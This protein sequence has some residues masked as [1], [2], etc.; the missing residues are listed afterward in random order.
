M[1]KEVTFRS[2]FTKIL[3]IA[4]LFIVLPMMF[5]PMAQ[6][7]TS[8]YLA[9]VACFFLLTIISIKL[10]L[11]ERE[12]V[13]Y[14]TIAFIIQL[15]L[16]LVHYLYFVDSS[17]FRSDGITTSGFWHEYLSV[18]DAIERLQNARNSYGIFYVMDKY[19]FRVSHPEIWHIISF[20][21][22]FLQHKWLNYSPFNLFSSLIASCNIMLFYKIR[23]DE[24]KDVHKALLFWTAY[25]PTFL[26]CGNLW[27]DPFGVML[28][29]VGL[30]LVTLSNSSLSKALSLL[31]LC[32]FSF[33][34]RTVY[35]VLSGVASVW[36]YL[37][38]SKKSFVKFLYIILG[39]VLI[40]F[41]VK[42]TEN[43]NTEGYNSNYVNSM[44]FLALPMKIVLGLI[45]PFP[46]TNF[47]VGV[48]SNPA[49]AWEVKDYVMGFFQLGYLFALIA[50]WKRL[51]FKNLDAMTVM[52]FG[53]MLSGL[54]TRHLHIGY[55][56]EGLLFTLPW[57]F[58]QIG[59]EYKKYIKYSFITLLFLNIVLMA[60]GHLGIAN[61]WK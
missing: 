18:Y 28:I 7:T 45:G 11:G 59:S 58:S 46:W 20:P 31:I 39:V 57:F 61:L 25:F 30:V 37:Q 56:S 60:V 1:Y 50:N 15:I 35:L 3:I 19:E 51:S 27:R 4:G 34:Q 16:G 33:M 41:L 42:Y 47:F 6:T 48:A 17:Y 53:I 23:F 2:Y 22:Y 21:F 24:D 38:K 26:L 10:I 55:I 49:F 9:S 43:A 29:S 54:L 40:Y 8:S 13:R 44:S 52:G 36:G 12:Y 5:A 14:Y 32:V